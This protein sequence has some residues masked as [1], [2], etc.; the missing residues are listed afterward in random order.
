[1][2]KAL[3]CQKLGRD[4]NDEAFYE[5]LMKPKLG[6]AAITCLLAWFPV[7]AQQPGEILWTY[8]ASGG[9]TASPAIAPDGT[10][11]IVVDM[12]GGGSLYAIG[13]GGTN[14]W[15]AQTG[16]YYSTPAVGSSGTVYVGSQTDGK[17]YA[18]T[19]TG[20]TNWIYPSGAGINSSPAIAL[21]GTIYFGSGERFY[22]V[23]SDGTKRWDFPT[24]QIQRASPS[25]A[26]DGT[27][28]IG[29]ETNR[30]YALRPNG[31]QRWT[32]DMPNPVETSPAI[33]ADGTIY[34]TCQYYSP[35][36]ARVLVAISPAGVERWRQGAG[37]PFSYPVV[38]KDGTIYV[39][40]YGTGNLLALDP[41][42]GALE[43]QAGGDS[44][45]YGDLP[46]VPA[47]A[48]NGLIYHGATGTDGRFYAINPNGTTNWVLNVTP[49]IL[50]SPAVG[51]DGTVYFCAYT[52][53]YA[54]KGVAPLANS[55]WPKYKQ[56][57][58]NTGK[59]EKP[60]LAQPHK[61][62]DGGFQFQLQ[63]ELGQG[64]TVLGCTNLNSWTSLTSFVATT[65]PMEVVDFT[66]T[67]FPIRFYRASSP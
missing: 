13:P 4:A 17:L 21:D 48:D 56:N 36:G 19:P 9:I 26:S 38:S 30:L 31:T 24:G 32:F 3:K 5:Q 64:Y 22:A 63:G 58:R 25:V 16:S 46:A 44:N 53:L 37:W 55:P 14:K 65:V 34:C 42:S 67:N 12:A 41:A 8:Q 62:S 39:V 54:V 18:I 27:I 15:H 10:I 49:E 66:A 59:V 2:T 40:N 43:W 11:Y 61:R 7:C 35:V 29:T 47:I 28:Y 57:L 23:N 45:V 60:S 6:S 20:T 1:V 33:G 52:S 50:G 51:P